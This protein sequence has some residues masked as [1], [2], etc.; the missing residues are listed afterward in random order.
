[1]LCNIEYDILDMLAHSDGAA[2]V[3]GLI[4]GDPTAM[5]F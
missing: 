2:D 5:K 1:M 3:D 4:L